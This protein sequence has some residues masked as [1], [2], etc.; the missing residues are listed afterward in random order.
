MIWKRKQEPEP[1]PTTLFDPGRVDLITQS[2]SGV[3]HLIVVQ[4][5]P[6]SDHPEERDSLVRKIENYIRYAAS[7]ALAHQ[8]PELTG[9]R[10]R[11]IIDTYFGRPGETTLAALR[12]ITTTLPDKADGI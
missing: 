6:W 5:Q 4:D 7:G 12:R 1:D 11:V 9:K 2:A 8:H 3:V 10:W